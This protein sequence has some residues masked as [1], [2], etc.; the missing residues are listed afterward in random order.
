LAI[1]TSNN[2]TS[3][4]TTEPFSS[5]LYPVIQG[6]KVEAAINLIFQ[7]SMLFQGILGEEEDGLVVIIENPCSSALSYTINGA[8][9]SFM[10]IGDLHDTKYNDLAIA[11]EVVSLVGGAYMGVPL[12]PA[13]C[14]QTI[15]FYPSEKLQ[16]DN[17]SIVP[18]MFTFGTICI[19]L[20]T[21]I[22]FYIYDMLVAYRQQKVIKAGM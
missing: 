11:I 20:F 10:G 1:L 22:L 2:S 4:A 16:K 21:W 15:S 18:L 8:N 9:V 12:D 6:T 17:K 19:F 3:E 14:P 5:I 7:W 13:Y